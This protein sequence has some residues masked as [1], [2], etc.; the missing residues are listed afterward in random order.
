[1]FK[2][3]YQIW[4]SL[5]GSGIELN[6]KNT[7]KEWNCVMEYY[8]FLWPWKG[9]ILCLSLP[10]CTD[11][12]R[13]RIVTPL[14]WRL[15]SRKEAHK[16]ASR[17]RPSQR[18]LWANALLWYHCSWMELASIRCLHSARNDKCNKSL[19]A[20]G[21]TR[22]PTQRQTNAKHRHVL[23]TE[24]TEFSLNMSCFSSVN[25]QEILGAFALSQY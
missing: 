17:T 9:G 21:H 15:L 16:T 10:L 2:F 4:A 8:T 24:T 22:P 23:R 20:V 1:M 19:P 18:S 13:C 12:T 3:W 5:W 11:K 6:V 14:F 25:C 7:L